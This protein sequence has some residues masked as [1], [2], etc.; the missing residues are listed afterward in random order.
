[1]L[2]GKIWLHRRILDSY[3]WRLP[4]AQLKV[5]LHVLL[6]ANWEARTWV[7]EEGSQVHLTPGQRVVGLRR[8][9]AECGISLGAVRRALEVLEAGGTIATSATRSWTTV[10]VLNWEDYQGP[11][12][13]ERHTREIADGIADRILDE[14]TGGI[15]GGI[16]DGPPLK[17]NKKKKKKEEREAPR[18][19]PALPLPGFGPVAVSDPAPVATERPPT[20]EARGGA[21]N[22]PPGGAAEAPRP[23]RKR[24]TGT[25]HPDTRNF[26][27]EFQ[28]LFMAHRGGVKPQWGEKQMSHVKRLLQTHGLQDCVARMRRMFALAPKWPAENPDLMC[29]VGHWDKFAPAPEP[30]RDVRFGSAPPAPH[31]AFVS[32]RIKI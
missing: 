17:K 12:E 9:A 22:E 4:P 24:S 18:S 25:A 21:E 19:A 7:T 20:S 8:L 23:P 32:G 27:D 30:K 31:H 11:L 1:M 3:V 10:T 5:F 14:I 28:S 15:T 6:T 16:T 29:L 26:T 13:E 2:F